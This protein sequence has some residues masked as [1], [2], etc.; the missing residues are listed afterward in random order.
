MSSIEPDCSACQVDCGEKIDGGFV[1]ARGDSA[2]LLELAEEVFNEVTRFVEFDVIRA[3]IF[4]GALGRDHRDLSRHPQPLY[5][6]FIGIERLVG[7]ERICGHVRQELIGAGQIVGLARRQ[8]EVQWI[9][10]RIGYGVDLGAQSA[11]AAPDGLV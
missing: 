1:V 4:A 9:A 2:E 3:R 7:Q 8:E 6:P 11:F 10:E 5:H